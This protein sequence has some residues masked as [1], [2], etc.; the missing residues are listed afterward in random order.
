MRNLLTIFV[1]AAGMQASARTVSVPAMPVSPYADT[2]VSTNVAINK[3]QISYSDLEFHFSGTPTNNLELAFGTDANTNGVLDAEEVETRFGWRGGRYFVEN[4]RT[5]EMFDGGAS[6]QSQNFSV[7]LHLEVRHGSQQVRKVVVSGANASDFGSL[8]TNVP[9]AWVWR[10]EWDLMRATRRG[11]EP[12]PSSDIAS[13]CS[14][15]SGD[16]SDWIYYK[17][18]NFGF[19][20][21]MR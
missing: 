11:A 10:R 2:E 3:A 1:A 18:A 4:A 20:I 16:M 13:Q 17:T 7:N 21:R 6:G 8:V 14:P 12:H 19:S 15:C 9:P 5:W